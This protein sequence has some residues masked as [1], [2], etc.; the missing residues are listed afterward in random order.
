MRAADL[1]EHFALDGGPGEPAEL[2]DEL[3]HGTM[4]P[5]L[6]VPCDVGAEIALQPCFVI[7]MRAGRI[8]RSPLLPV[9]I[10]RRDVDEFLA[11]TRFRAMS[12]AD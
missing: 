12:D 9:R 4:A 8:A 1:L 10:G 5:E 2:G 6:A 3:P 11:R 7:P